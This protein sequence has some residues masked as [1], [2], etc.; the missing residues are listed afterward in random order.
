VKPL[1]NIFGTLIANSAKD[2]VFTINNREI[3]RLTATN[4]S[5]IFVQ[6]T[7][8]LNPQQAPIITGNS[9]CSK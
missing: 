2:E 9:L 1:V 4:S 7:A 8:L 5:N 3:R 6:E